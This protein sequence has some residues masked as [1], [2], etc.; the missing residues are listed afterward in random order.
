LFITRYD[1]SHD[2]RLTFMEFSEAFLPAD[3]YHSH[4]LNRRCANPPRTM[5]RRDDCFLADTQIEFRS[6]WR[7]HFKIECASETLRQRLS[8]RPMFNVYEAFNSLDINDDGRV[9]LDELKRM[10]QSRG[11]NVADKDLY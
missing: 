2:R 1:R 5:Y 7:T 11:Y 9:T 6:M 4:Q 3:S 8:S 10:I